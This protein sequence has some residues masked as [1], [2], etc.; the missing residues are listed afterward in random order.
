MPISEHGFLGKEMV[1]LVEEVRRTHADFFS[2]ADEV[3]THCQQA[4]YKLAPHNRHLQEMLVTTLFMRALTNFQGAIVLAERGMMPQ[5]RVL[6]RTTIEGLFILCAISKKEKYATEFVYDDHKSRLAFLNKF[7][8]FHGGKLPEDVDVKEVEALESE[9]KE[10]VKVSEIRKKSTEQWAKD[11]D[12]HDWYLSA[13]ALLSQS[14][15]SKVKDLEG[16]LVISQSE[17][18]K[19]LQWGP[20]DAGIEKLLMTI[21]QSMLIALRCAARMFSGIDA[22]VDIYQH[23]LDTLIVERLSDA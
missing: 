8:K 6:A 22:Q 20:A 2:L 5:S 9:L 19:E 17:E 13:Y 21:I 23:R 15:H 7:R 14:V 12:M 18:V 16:Y 3:N 10:E 1:A 11:A 4:M